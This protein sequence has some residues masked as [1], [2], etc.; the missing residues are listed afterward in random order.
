MREAVRSGRRA[1]FFITENRFIDDYAAK[2]GGNGVAIYCILS[3]RANWETKETWVSADRMASDL[4]ISKSTVYRHLKVL[5]DLRLIRTLRTREKTIYVILPVPPSRTDAGPTPLFDAIIA[6]DAV[7]P[8]G[9]IP[10]S[11]TESHRQDSSVSSV[12]H[13]VAPVTCAGRTS[14]NR[15]K[16]EQD[17]FNKTHEQDF[18]GN[19]TFDDSKIKESAQRLIQILKLKDSFTAT[20]ISAVREEM[21]RTGRAPEDV[22]PRLAT[23]ANQAFRRRVPITKFFE[24][25]AART[26]ARQIVQDLSLPATT[27]LI[28]IIAAA[29]LAEADYK[30]MSIEE[31]AGTITQAAVDDSHEGVPI[32]KF[33]FEDTKWR[34]RGRTGKGRKQFARI[35]RARDEAHAII[36]AQMDR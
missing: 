11:E 36:D 33:Y 35:K 23:D 31:A 21:W 9:T 26:C 12:T 13:S 29:V 4:D 5:E 18:M 20:A 17:S 15:N 30:G 14:E 27:N 8:M 6:E 28:S 2:V 32:D 25:L 16:E 1:N 34:S 10:T 22:V 7:A 3:R 19:K 24:D